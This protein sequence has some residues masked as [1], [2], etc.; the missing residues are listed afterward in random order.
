MKKRRGVVGDITKRTGALKKRS[1]KKKMKEGGEKT[2]GP[3][4]LN[5]MEGK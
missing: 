1:S 3:R 4:S 5:V 2:M